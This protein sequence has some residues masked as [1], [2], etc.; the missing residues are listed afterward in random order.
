VQCSGFGPPRAEHRGGEPFSPC[1]PCS[2]PCTPWF[3]W[4][5]WPQGHIAASCQPGLN[6]WPTI[7]QP[8]LHWPS[9][10]PGNTANSWSAYNG[11]SLV[12]QDTIGLLGHQDTLLPQSQ[13]VVTHWPTRTP[14][15][16]LASRKHHCLIVNCWPTIHQREHRWP[17][18]PPGHTAAS[19]SGC[20]QPLSP[21]NRSSTKQSSE[22]VEEQEKDANSSEP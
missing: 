22:P 11:Q 8:R 6:R 12:N 13:P 10:P 7:G 1:W 4:P 14:L 3:H 5:S 17:S 15:A 9:W 18:W 20:G 21:T 2:V 16:F 19:R